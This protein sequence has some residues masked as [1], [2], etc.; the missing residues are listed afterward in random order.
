MD[1]RQI[2]SLAARVP[3]V[4]QGI[5]LEVGRPRLQLLEYQLLHF[6]PEDCFTIS[7]LVPIP[8]KHRLKFSSSCHRVWEL[9]THELFVSHGSLTIQKS[10]SKLSEEF[11]LGKTLRALQLSGIMNLRLELFSGE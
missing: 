5:D 1:E 4:A 3:I 11:C 8:V 9:S 7:W 10:K 2:T 6:L